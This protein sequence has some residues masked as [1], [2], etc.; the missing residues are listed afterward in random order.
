MQRMDNGWC[1][2]PLHELSAPDVYDILKL[3][4]EVFVVEQ[5]CVY[6]DPDGHDRRAWH[7]LYRERGELLAYQRCLAPGAAYA[8]ASAI[9]R[10]VVAAGARGRNLGREL[11]QRGIRFNLARWPQC[12]IRIGAQARLQAFYESLGFSVC[13]EP[14]LEDGIRHL[15][16]EL[17]PPQKAAGELR[18]EGC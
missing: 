8:E 15:E 16:M 11:V 17:A 12:R 14:Y 1:C 18:L 13:S 3:R 7:W 6:L 2:K 5:Q 10:I 9:G 4:A